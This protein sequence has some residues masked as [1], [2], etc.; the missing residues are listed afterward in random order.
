MK[1]KGTVEDMDK[2]KVVMWTGWGLRVIVGSKRATEAVRLAITYDNR[3]GE[4][5]SISFTK[6]PCL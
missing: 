4:T 6:R 1:A 2:N 5:I 3:T